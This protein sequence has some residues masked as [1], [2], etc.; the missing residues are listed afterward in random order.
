[1][2]ANNMNDN[3][4]FKVLYFIALVAWRYYN[5]DGWMDGWMDVIA[6]ITGVYDS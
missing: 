5:M 3:I 2:R 6:H 4:G 1:M